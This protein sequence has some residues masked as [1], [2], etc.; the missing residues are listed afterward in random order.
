MPVI[1]DKVQLAMDYLP[2]ELKKL[3]QSNNPRN[4]CFLNMKHSVVSISFWMC[5]FSEV[6]KIYEVIFYVII[7][8]V[9]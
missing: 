9:S 2:A 4:L 7:S 5:F 3:A 8:D 6:F 1:L